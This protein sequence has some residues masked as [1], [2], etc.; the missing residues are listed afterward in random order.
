MDWI[1]VTRKSGDG[2]NIKDDKARS[3]YAEALMKADR[4]KEEMKDGSSKIGFLPASEVKTS[5]NPF[6]LLDQQDEEALND[7]EAADSQSKRPSEDQSVKSSNKRTKKNKNI[8][9]NDNFYDMCDG[10]AKLPAPE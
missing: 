9:S 6:N 4:N 2:E 1:K 10:Y 3:I 5:E 8:N 7:T